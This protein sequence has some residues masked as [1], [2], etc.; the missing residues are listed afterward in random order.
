MPFDQFAAVRAVVD[1]DGTGLRD[2]DN[3]F[4]PACSGFIMVSEVVER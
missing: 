1:D 2:V 4:T 3:R